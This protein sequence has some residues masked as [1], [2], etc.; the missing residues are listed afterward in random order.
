MPE[1]VLFSDKTANCKIETI[2]P[3]YS[4]RPVNEGGLNWK[5]IKNM[6]ITKDILW[7][8]GVI[9]L[10]MSREYDVIILLGS[11]YHISTWAAMILG[12]IIKKP[13]FLW[14]HGMLKNEGGLK[15]WLRDRFYKLSS[16][17]L[18]YGNYAKDILIKRGYPAETLHVVYNSLNYARQCQIKKTIRQDELQLLKKELFKYAE[19]PVLVFIGRLTSEKKL[20]M[21]IEAMNILQKEQIYLNL[22]LIGEGSERNS[23]MKTLNHY[24]LDDY[25]KLYGECYD[26]EIIG[27][28]ISMAD[29]CVTPAALGL[30]CMH[31]LI[32]GT[33]VITHNNFTFQNP[34]VE[35]VKEGQTGSY[36]IMDDIGDLSEKIK[37]WVNT[38][39]D[40]NEVKSNCEKIIDDY[41][42]PDYQAKI[43]NEVVMK[44]CKG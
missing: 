17:L 36:F 28:L 6:W 2:D 39:H 16:G 13:V 3:E 19:L 43:F 27:R 40:K 4:T 12:R 34:E 11:L 1:Y 24:Q 15:G 32:Y 22:L 21:I 7:Q 20:P 38:K 31:S 29:I 35:A 14:T 18:L 23:I 26:E 30:T 41:Y 25:V 33:P 44:N 8:K 5:F 10:V 37:K 42:N 9:A